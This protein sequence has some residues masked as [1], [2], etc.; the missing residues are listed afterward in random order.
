MNEIDFSRR[1]II[2]Y[3]LILGWLLLIPIFEAQ[4]RNFG[5]GFMPGLI[6]VLLIPCVAIGT[7]IDFIIRLFAAYLCSRYSSLFVRVAAVA[8]PLFLF[9]LALRLL[10]KIFF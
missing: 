1:R 8:V 3:S 9:L 10:I 7:G 2:I 6:S 4:S 5:W